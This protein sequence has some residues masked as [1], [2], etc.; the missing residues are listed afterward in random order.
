MSTPNSYGEEIQIL[1]EITLKGPPNECQVFFT[2]HSPYV[3]DE[4]LQHPEQVYCLDRPKPLAGATIQRLS[5]SRR[6]R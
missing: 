4:F 3:L 6:S 2:T 1:R 5:D